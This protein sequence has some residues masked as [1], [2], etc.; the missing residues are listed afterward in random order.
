MSDPKFCAERKTDPRL[1][2]RRLLQK[3]IPPYGARVVC[4]T[5][6][7]HNFLRVLNI[8]REYPEN[9]VRR[10]GRTQDDTRWVFLSGRDLTIRIYAWNAI[11]DYRALAAL[12]SEVY[13]VDQTFV[14][15]VGR[16]FRVYVDAVL[17]ERGLRLRTG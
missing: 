13:A 3:L 8:Q 11:S 6:Y 12:L 5:G 7:S 9:N 4:A 10:T 2:G 14:R 1:L 16:F 15:L 17:L